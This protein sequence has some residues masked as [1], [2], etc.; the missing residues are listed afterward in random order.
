MWRFF[1]Y[2]FLLIAILTVIFAV[3]VP[4][5]ATL[6]ELCDLSAW[7]EGALNARR[8]MLLWR[9]IWIAL[10]AAGVAQLFG[11]GLAAGLQAKSAFM[12]GLT[13]IVGLWVLLMPPYVYAYAWSLPLLPEGLA[14]GPLLEGDL[15]AWLAT[16]GRAILCLSAWCAPLAAFVLAA[17]WRQARPAW[18]LML[19]D[20]RGW[21]ATLGVSC[22]LLRPWLILSLTITFLLAIA[23]Y[24]V[25]HLCLV[26][27]WNTEILAATLIAERAGQATILA[28][29]LIVIQLLVI[30]GLW[31]ARQS[32]SRLIQAVGEF[33]LEPDSLGTTAVDGVIWS[34]VWWLICVV[35]ILLPLPTLLIY[36]D[37]PR[38][39][40]ELWRVYPDD[41]PVSLLASAGAG[42][43]AI[44]IATGG[45]ALWLIN[46]RVA[47]M[48]LT[49]CVA[50]FA[51][52]MLL[53]PAVV[54]D[55]FTA[56]YVQA[57]A[58]IPLLYA[59]SEHWPI[60]SL[61]GVARFGVLTLVLVLLRVQS[62]SPDV[63]AQA[64]LE[65]RGPLTIWREVLL[66]NLWTTLWVGGGLVAILTLGEVAATQM[67]RPP[68]V[69]N[70]A[71]TLLNAI[72]FGRQ[73]Q[74]IAMSVVL[75]G[76][77]GV[78]VTVGVVIASRK[79]R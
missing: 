28:W 10:C 73:D 13:L 56:A 78:L 51:A 45:A 79:R 52:L 48:G 39:F 47:K 1:S 9:G 33:N 7:S 67:V 23:E 15:H 68:N 65:T 12:R 69:P 76:V 42:F 29:P 58:K 49:L 36:L 71:V 3:G 63:L 61:L 8:L 11:A 27:T 17:G 43:L 38:A 70:L 53:P 18:Q 14:V 54:G 6:V 34:R 62:I 2:C 77:I 16:K 40:V 44:C 31:L 22:G 4:L 37:E 59:I 41:W 19:T 66:P 55:A 26:Q 25:C 46:S 74:I 60:V 72:H 30:G 50:L 64:Q 75:F 21:R 35:V 20:A 5:L 57:G 32:L 24:S